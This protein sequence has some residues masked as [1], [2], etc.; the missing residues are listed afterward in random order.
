MWASITEENIG[1]DKG[2]NIDPG[3]NPNGD[4][5]ELP[6][7]SRICC[8]PKGDRIGNGSE[9]RGSSPKY[10]CMSP[11][12]EL[13]SS[14]GSVNAKGRRDLDPNG[15]LKNGSEKNGSEENGSIVS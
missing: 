13:K 9:K 14:K 6:K 12:R 8:V 11:K 4:G 3:P 5:M 15:E 10:L 7:G 1:P 2:L